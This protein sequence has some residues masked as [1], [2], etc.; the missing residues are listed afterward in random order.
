VYWN[1]AAQVKKGLLVAGPNV[2]A[3]QVSDSA[4]A[5]G[6]GFDLDL[7]YSAAAAVGSGG[8]VRLKEQ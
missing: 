3:A 1:A 8:T 4:G 6:S 5:P 7:V 2:I